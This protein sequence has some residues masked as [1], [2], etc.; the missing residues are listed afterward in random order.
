MFVPYFKWILPSF[1][2]KGEKKR[3]VRCRKHSRCRGAVM[4]GRNMRSS[5]ILQ[6][7]VSLFERN[8]ASK[9]WIKSADKITENHADFIIAVTGDS[10]RSELRTLLES[11]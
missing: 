3:E 10:I 4:K 11:V 2:R 8:S 6:R 5:A 1:E 9:N 7:C